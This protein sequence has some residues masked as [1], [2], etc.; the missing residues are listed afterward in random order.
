MIIQ[1]NKKIRIEG[2][3][4]PLQPVSALLRDENTGRLVRCKTHPCG[5]DG[6]F[7][8]ELAALTA[9]FTP[10]LLEITQNEETQV[11]RD[12]LIGEVWLAAGQSNMALPLCNSL[13]RELLLNKIKNQKIRFLHSPGF[14][15][16][17]AGATER[18]ARPLKD[19][20]SC[21]WKPVQDSA[22]VLGLSAMAL[23]FA[24]SLYQELDVPVGIL[25]TAVGGTSLETWI[26][27]KVIDENSKITRHL[28][29]TSRYVP[30]NEYNQRGLAN[31]NQMSGL[32]NEKIAPLLSLNIRG[33]IWLQG[34]SSAGS[35]E[36]ASFYCLAIKKMIADWNKGFRDKN[37]PFLLAH[38]S[39]Q[40]YQPSRF[41]VCYL[42][43]ALS[44]AA[45]SMAPI[46]TQIPVYD[47]PLD[48]II[49]NDLQSHPIHPGIKKFT[50][51]RFAQA[52][53]AQFYRKPDFSFFTPVF[54]KMEQKGGELL[55]TFTN[56]GSGLN[57]R[58]SSTLRGF[59]I[60][61]IDGKHYDAEASICDRDTVSLRHE[62][63]QNPVEAT[64]AFFDISLHANLCGEGGIPAIPFRTN[65]TG[66]L[67]SVPKLWAACDCKEV[68][69][70]SFEWTLGGA[71]MEPLWVPGLLTGTRICRLSFDSVNKSEGDA[72]LKIVYQ[73]TFETGCFIGVSP[74]I[75][76]TG[77]DHQLQCYDFL[78]VDIMN[79][80]DYG[81]I[82][83]GVLIRT[84]HAGIYLLPVIEGETKGVNI[85]IRAN[86]GFVR[87]K[88]SLKDFIGCYLINEAKTPGDLS[89]ICEMQ[90]T[91]RD[92]NKLNPQGT[93]YL[94]NIRFGC[95]PR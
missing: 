1:Q 85:P 65:R 49:P 7:V 14:D 31:Y 37:Q 36:E 70:N 3:G 44:D 47:L 55:I 12:I 38:I 15:E 63:I 67:Y 22:A 54:E 56:T 2:E 23:S 17:K 52:A 93:L 61:G 10:Y 39:G 35:E 34:E 82:F 71:K 57:T 18:P 8:L 30:E 53:L 87:Y 46:V 76:H 73:A 60:A 66:Q 78:T 4:L 69:V 64:Y 32:Y 43:E 9:S 13:D 6:N 21:G 16:E 45:R 59:T 33:T 11:V 20:P 75:H 29:K 91:F 19:L 80:D 94:D 68:W 5:A 28:K 86:S 74:M 62:F 77:Y 51:E 88:V 42:N 41:G 83:T 40:N 90:F 50:G 24:L 79:P 92:E 95:N 81:K 48:W 25:N 26:S 89:D 84:S 27:R 72:S 58:K